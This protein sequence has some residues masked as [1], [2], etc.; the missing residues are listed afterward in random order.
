M[1]DSVSLWMSPGL[2]RALP[3]SF[4]G[5]SSAAMLRV[6]SYLEAI[7]KGTH[8]A[9]ITGETGTGKELIARALHEVSGRRGE[10]IAV[11]VA[12][13]DDTMA[14]RPLEYLYQRF[15]EYIEDRRR[16]PR[17]DVLTEQQDSV[18]VKHRPP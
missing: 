14:H 12:G 3:K 6:F 8:P 11:N 1:R 16:A 15:T 10:F 5:N 13:L 17:D 9:L 4:A 2:N 18:V 7:A